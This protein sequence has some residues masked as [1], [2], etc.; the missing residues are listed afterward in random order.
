VTFTGANTSATAG[1][2]ALREG[3][4]EEDGPP[5]ADHQEA[6]TAEVADQQDVDQYVAR[7]FTAQMSRYMRMENWAHNG[8]IGEAQAQYEQDKWRKC[9]RS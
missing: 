2:Y 9:A 6:R 1:E 4:G 8:G 7:L 5:R 3:A